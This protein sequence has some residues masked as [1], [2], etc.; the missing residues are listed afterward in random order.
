[1]R[2][3][4]FRSTSERK[5]IKPAVDLVLL[6]IRSRFNVGAMFRT[7]DAVGISRI[8]LLGYTPRPPHKEIDKVALGAEKTVPFSSHATPLLYL[9]N[10]KKRGYS[11]V[12]LE[13]GRKTIKYFDYKRPKKKIALIVGHE[14]S[15]IDPKILKLCDAIISIPMRGRKKSL[16]VGIAVGIVAYRIAF[17]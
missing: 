7:A 17:P 1:M 2:K 14:V 4:N 10:L 5:L 16:N 12:A 11:L 3:E 15:G 9:K 8:Y 6:N 13:T